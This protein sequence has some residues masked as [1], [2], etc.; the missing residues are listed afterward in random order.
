M[1]QQAALQQSALHRQQANCYKEE[2]NTPKILHSQESASPKLGNEVS[3]FGISIL[4]AI[5]PLTTKN[6][7]QNVLTEL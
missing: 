1:L 6:N 2:F 3:H 5:L 4:T 7:R